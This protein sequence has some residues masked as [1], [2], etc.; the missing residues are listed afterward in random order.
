V[1]PAEVFGSS[2]PRE[3]FPDLHNIL[4][5]IDFFTYIIRRIHKFNG[6][7][8]KEEGCM[9]KLRLALLPAALLLWLI[10]L[11]VLGQVHLHGTLSGSLS[12]GEY[13]VDGDCQVP[14]GDTLAIQAG[15]VLKFSGHYVFYVYGHMTALGTEQDSILFVRLNPDE[16][17]KHGGVRFYNGSTGLMQ[18]CHVDYAKNQTTPSGWGGGI[19]C[20][21][22]QVAIS[23]CLISNCNAA[24]GGGLYATQG[25][26]LSVDNSLFFNN[27][28]TS[29]GGGLYIYQSPG[30]YVTHSLF[31]K[32]SCAGT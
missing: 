9:L 6:N 16:I 27:S 14:A 19:Y 10:P 12:S 29:S 11:L 31:L 2:Q 8:L 22:A 21:G 28:A 18:Y 7:L 4:A 3:N 15:A 5:F 17:C 25:T 26:G 23:H 24:Y 13:I 32:N 20:A 1:A 30:A